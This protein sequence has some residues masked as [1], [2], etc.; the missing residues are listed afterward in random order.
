M[1]K[2]LTL[3]VCIIAT[4]YSCQKDEIQESASTISQR[5][6]DQKSGIVENG[7]HY[8]SGYGQNPIDDTIYPLAFYTSD[9]YQST[10]IPNPFFVEIEIIKTNKQLEAFVERIIRDRTYINRNGTF[11]NYYTRMKQDLVL[12]EKTI[13]I[14]ARISLQRYK[15]ITDGFPLL[16][17]DAYTL[18][19]QPD[20]EAKFLN[21]YGKMYVDTQ[22]LGGHVYYMYTYT[23]NNLN[24]STI[25]AFERDIKNRVQ[26]LFGGNGYAMSDQQIQIID[27]KRIATGFYTNIEGL[28]PVIIKSADDFRYEIERVQNH[29]TINPHAAATVDIQFK[30]YAD[31]I[32]R[33]MFKDAFFNE[34]KCYGDIVLW[35][36]ELAELEFILN[37]TNN[38][39]LKIATRN[40]I[41]EIKINISSAWNCI[42]INTPT[43]NQYAWIK[44]S[45]AQEMGLQ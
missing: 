27:N 43:G 5:D 38:D 18:L 36:K 35:R 40:A 44:S 39:N 25:T 41:E 26:R 33:P 16:N 3:I 31:L 19:N 32:D 20:G 30:S 7:R 1:K 14:A 45:Y 37:N 34:S 24:S 12:S 8:F 22:T 4:L 42:N 11:T 21:K 17:D 2:T 28:S 13:T 29:L 10:N 15:Y 6:T 23:D 9:L